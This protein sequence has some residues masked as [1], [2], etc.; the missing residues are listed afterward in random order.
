MRYS[1]QVMLAGRPEA[2]NVSVRPDA[3]ARSTCAAF[4]LVAPYRRRSA[5]LAGGHES[6]S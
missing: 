4:V 2:R 5:G 1:A 3:F 6:S